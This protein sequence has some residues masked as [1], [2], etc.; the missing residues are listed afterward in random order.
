MRNAKLLLGILVVLGCSGIA[1]GQMAMPD[2]GPRL[3][4]SSP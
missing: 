2:L 4:N 1:L 3:V